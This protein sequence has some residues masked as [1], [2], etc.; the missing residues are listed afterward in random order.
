MLKL[1]RLITYIQYELKAFAFVTWRAALR[2]KRRAFRRNLKRGVKNPQLRERLIPDYRLGCKRIL[3]SNDFYPALD[4]PNVELVTDAITEVR[5]DSIVTADGKARKADAIIFATGFTATDFLA[6]IAIVGLGGKD[7]RQ[8]WSNAGAQAHLGMTVAGFPNFFMLYGPNTNLAHN[9]IV[10]MIESQIHYILKCL[11]RLQRGEIR[12]IDVKKDRQDR[13][14]AALQ[15]R[16]DKATW[17]KGCTSW[18]LNAAGRNVANW[19]GYSLE[20]RLR[21]RAPNW[22]DYA[23]H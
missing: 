10:Y 6:P 7:L 2:F 9:S 5:A 15:K 1:S 11:T 17:S 19:P 13:F 3:F 23:V 8:S 16:L 14:N 20:F 12:S 22:D 18:Y 21:T 4:R